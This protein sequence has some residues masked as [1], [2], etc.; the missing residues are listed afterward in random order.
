MGKRK[1]FLVAD[2][3]T[4]S[5]YDA[6]KAKEDAD[7]QLKQEY[8]DRGGTITKCPPLTPGGLR[9]YSRGNR[10]E[11]GLVLTPNGIKVS[12]EERE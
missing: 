2:E 3:Y 10:P 6:W 5:I 11:R 8:F 1:A 12:F 4:Q 9:V 7:D